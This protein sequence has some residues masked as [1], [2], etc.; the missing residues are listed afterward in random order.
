M[1]TYFY[2]A[3][4]DGVMEAVPALAE[5]ADGSLDA[6]SDRQQTVLHLAAMKDHAE[7]VED[8]SQ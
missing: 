8:S 5:A 6:K 4:H 7:V 3:A 2:L 1:Y